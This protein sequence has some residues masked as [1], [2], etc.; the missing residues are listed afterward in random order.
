MSILIVDDSVDIRNLHVK[1]LKAEGY[2]SVVTASSA[3]E[4]F[5]HLGMEDP[6]S[7]DPR[8]DLILMDITMPEMDGVEACFWI[9]A[10]P[11]LRDIPIIMVTSHQEVNYL[12]EAFAAGAMDYINK[13]VHKVELRARVC[14]ALALKYETDRRKLAYLE[15][16]AKNR[17]LEE[18][19]LATSHAL[20]SVT[21]DLNQPLTSIAGYVDLMLLHPDK[22][23]PLNERQHKYLEK[24]MKS[25]H[26]IKSMVDDLLDISG[27]ESGNLEL[28]PSAFEVRP[29]IDRIIG[30]LTTQITQH[31]LDLEI[32][33]LEDLPPV[34][35]D[36]D[37]F[38]QV[39]ASLID[40]S[41]KY[42]EP[43]CRVTVSARADAETLMVEISDTG[44]G[45]AE[46]DQERVFD[47]FFR[48]DSPTVRKVSGA[49][50]GLFIARHLVEAQGGRIWVRS[51]SGEGS[52]FGFALPQ[53]P[54]EALDLDAPFS[55]ELMI[56]E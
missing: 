35:A 56:Q 24:V 15:L 31:Q 48:V 32:D 10:S 38:A 22:L 5:R 53:A 19:S 52:A 37:R 17:E 26:R 21:H 6:N 54:H 45:I 14:S 25:S 28:N 12:D 42:S 23:G 33:V 29:E 1:L 13:P 34:S 49:G 9:K 8:V 11:R 46:A 3:R 16:E 4:A 30:S 27:I 2:S 36:R 47:K 51:V 41:C 39:I 18:A 43:G 44:M 55:N 40:N 50:L 7:G 20:A